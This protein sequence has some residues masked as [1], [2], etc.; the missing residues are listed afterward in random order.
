MPD[1]KKI[2]QS[3]GLK[4]ALCVLG[5]LIILLAIFQAGEAEKALAHQRS[6]KE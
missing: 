3:K 4:R 6:G 1:I 5:G 2:S